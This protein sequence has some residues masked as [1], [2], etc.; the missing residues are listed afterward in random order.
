[1]RRAGANRQARVSFSSQKE[2]RQKRGVRYHA[3]G[4]LSQLGVLGTLTF[5]TPWTSCG[6]RLGWIDCGRMPRPA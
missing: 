5:A 6:G 3:A 2:Q 4:H 1:L